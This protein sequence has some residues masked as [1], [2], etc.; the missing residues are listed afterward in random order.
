MNSC[1]L[2]EAINEYKKVNIIEDES[3]QE[4][5]IKFYNTIYQYMLTNDNFNITKFCRIHNLK[6]YVCEDNYLFISPT[7]ES[8][9]TS[10]L[11]LNMNPDSSKL[12]LEVPHLALESV[13]LLA[14]AYFRKGNFKLMLLNAQVPEDPRFEH[15]I[16]YK[17]NSQYQDLNCLFSSLLFDHVFIQLHVD[18]KLDHENLVI[19]NG[20]GS[21]VMNSCAQ[22]FSN[23]LQVD[24]EIDEE[25]C[26]T[27]VQARSFNWDHDS[28]KFMLI[29]QSPVFTKVEEVVK[30][31]KQLFVPNI[32]EPIKR[33]VPELIYNDEAPKPTGAEEEEQKRKEEELKTQEQKE[34]EQRAL[35]NRR[36][37]RKQ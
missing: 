27:N 37:K 21:F 32:D 23:A 34:I 25:C 4:L 33:K 26:T 20:Y 18:D 15:D 31:F 28:G 1:T 7:N 22:Q 17:K 13:E 8:K 36:G 30:G 29:T 9:L 35:E 12:V 3:M 5:A 14:D 10:A 11:V 24:H 6:C 16:C 2:L 19:S